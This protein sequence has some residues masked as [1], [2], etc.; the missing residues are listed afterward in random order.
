[1]RHGDDGVREALSRR[2]RGYH[3]DEGDRVD[4]HAPGQ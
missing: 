2:E 4:T 3:G 1:M